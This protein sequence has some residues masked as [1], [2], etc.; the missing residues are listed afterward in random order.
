MLAL[1]TVGDLRNP[2]FD[3]A[4]ML[5]FSRGYFGWKARV[6]FNALQ[7]KTYQANGAFAELGQAAPGLDG[8]PTS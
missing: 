2:Y 5:S 4:N 8:S 7:H 3:R 1:V 6:A